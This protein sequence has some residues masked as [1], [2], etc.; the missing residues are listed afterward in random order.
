MSKSQGD[1]EA[2]PVVGAAAAANGQQKQ[3]RPS[4]GH[5]HQQQQQ[6]TNGNG[7]HQNGGGRRDSTQ[8]FTPLLAQHNSTNGGDGS[9][10]TPTAPTTMLYESTPSNNN[11]WK[12]SEDI[13]N[14]KNGLLSNNNGNGHSL[15]EKYAHEQAPLTGGYKLPPGG[16]AGGG[17]RGSE[18]EESDFDSDLNGGGDEGSNCGLFGCRPRWARRFA[19]THVFMVVFLLAYIL[20]GMYMTYFVSVITTIE[21]LFQIKSK[22]TGF[23][24]SASEMGQISTAMLLT[25]FAG[26][27]HRP[28]WIACGMVLFSIAAFACALPH[29]IFGEQ[30][31]QSSVFLQ[32]QTPAVS[33]V[34]SPLWSNATDPNLCTLGGN[35]TLAGSECNEQRQLEQASHSKITVIV[36]CIFFGS[37]LSSGIGQTAVA[38]LGIPYIDDNVGSKQSPM[39]MAVTI[40]MRILGP[41]SGFIVGSFCTRWYV[42]FA[43]PGFDASDPRWIGAW[44]L[45]PVAIGSLMLLASIAM[46]SF[47]KQLTGKQQ[48]QAAAA[49]AAAAPE[50][51]E[52]P[53]LKDFPKTVRRQLSNDILMFRTASCV[54]H[55]LPIAG[56][57]TFLP[58]YLETQF[59]L[60]TYDANMIAA[61]CGILVM[62]IGIV[63]SGLFILKRKPTARGVAAWIAFT[64]LVY[65]AGMIILMFIGCS[66]ND[67]AGY[68]PGDANS[69]AMIEPA[70]SAVL[71]CTCDKEN[72]APICGTDGKM[73]ISACHAGCSSSQ[74]R[75]SDNRT[76]Y[77]DCAC[78]PNVAEAVTGYCDNNCKNFIYFIA[79]FAICVFMHSTS[80]VGSMLLV[81]RCTHPKD[82]AM[83]MGVIQSAIGLF[84]NVPCPI[85]YGAVV[86]SACLIWKSVCGKHGA[87]SLYDADTFRQYFLGITAGIMFLAFLMD[88]V[89][90]RKA[91]L[92]DIAPDQQDGTTNATATRL[93]VSES[94][95]PIAP[96]PDTTV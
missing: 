48:T 67:F 47:P 33:A 68:K 38:T 71:N 6:Q 50:P 27:G 78:I 25:Y 43:N 17:A 32:P 84:G 70:C 10:A 74:L 96:P 31:M 37:L 24:L 85:I 9:T 87:C 94:K 13:N 95:Q 54:F 46:F 56:L 15:R 12:A 62:G 52:K 14:L 20:Q 40:G 45:G 69:P 88:L 19:S 89:V 77:T 7:Y 16:G 39:Y 41:A 66:T 59:R 82:K 42:N 76:L 34:S 80:E 35:G 49:I 11:E 90:W 53:K 75:F 93:D 5:A 73:Y 86:D 92:I 30:L 83:A 28:R 1:V 8:A 64:A 51:E 65:S 63:I 72:F 36:L 3:S 26:R 4:N 21:K 57:Y 61:F 29:F 58:K 23:L 2:P 22:T 18:S 55:L 79:I 44:W 60:A 81:M 91:H